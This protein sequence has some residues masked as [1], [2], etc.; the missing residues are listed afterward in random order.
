MLVKNMLL[1]RFDCTSEGWKG[2]NYGSSRAGTERNGFVA[3]TMGGSILEMT[4]SWSLS[5]GFLLLYRE[6]GLSVCLGKLSYEISGVQ[7]SL[8]CGG[9]F[10]DLLTLSRPINN[11][12]PLT[13]FPCLKRWLSASARST[14]PLLSAYRTPHL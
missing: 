9:S 3:V 14:R 1:N 10:P 5:Q 8:S 6:G 11:F 2:A 12:I 4:S 7:T 13:N